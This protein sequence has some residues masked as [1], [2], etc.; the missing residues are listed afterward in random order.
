[1]K[2]ITWNTQWCRGVDG[3]VDPTRIVKH[4]KALADFDVLCLQ[5]IANN[6]PDPRLAGSRGENQ[7]AEISRL[8]PVYQ[9]APGEAVDVP[10]EEGGRRHFGN[11]ILAPVPFRQGY[12][13]QLTYLARTL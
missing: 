2:L 7:F 6:F 8:L 10:S 9:P 5:E 12:R 3:K 1:M 4:A 13:H 11:K